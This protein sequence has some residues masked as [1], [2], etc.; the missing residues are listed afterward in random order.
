MLVD[1]LLMIIAG[2]AILALVF[3]REGNRQQKDRKRIRAMEGDYMR[4]VGKDWNYNG[5]QAQEWERSGYRHCA[6]PLGFLGKQK[7]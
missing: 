7:P 1:G 2:I 6:T 3:S 5:R 4:T